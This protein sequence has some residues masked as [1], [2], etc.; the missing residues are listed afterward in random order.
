VNSLAVLLAADAAGIPVEQAAASLASMR[1]PKGRGE[2]KLLRWGAGEITVID[3]SYNASPVSVRA[4]LA[5]L[6]SMKGRRVAVLGD[7]LEL[8]EQGP[9]LHSGL[10]E[11]IAEF[12]IDKVFTA[13]PL[14]RGLFDALNAE[15]KGAHAP[16]SS[17]LA[18]MVAA[19]LKAGD[20]VMVKGSAGSRMGRVVAHLE[21]LK[22]DKH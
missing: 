3:E 15:K 13:G 6:G 4:A 2:K 17:Q 18:P 1:P 5:T 16:D 8:G 19:A 20:V 7:M 10:A 11:T 14:M 22:G 21:G 12:D 9:V